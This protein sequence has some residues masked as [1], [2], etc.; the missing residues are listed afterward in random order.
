MLSRQPFEKS[1]GAGNAGRPL[2]RQ[3]RVQDKKAPEHS[4]TVTPKSPG[5]PYAMVSMVPSCFS[6]VTGLVC[7]RH[8]G[9]G[10]SKP[11]TSPPQTLRQRRGVGTTR[12]RR[13]R[14]PSFVSARFDRSVVHLHGPA[15]LARPPTLPSKGSGRETA[16]TTRTGRSPWRSGH[17]LNLDRNSSLEDV[18]AA[19]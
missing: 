1:E 4:H 14:E 2:R 13:P 12:F 11:P 5:I 3:P 19:D 10:V 16:V 15:L 17:G 9:C 18:T 8:W 6:P 7:H